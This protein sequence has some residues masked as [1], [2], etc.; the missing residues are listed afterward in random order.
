MGTH[1][2]THGRTQRSAPRRAARVNTRVRYVNGRHEVSGGVKGCGRLS[3]VLLSSGP[4][5]AGINKRVPVPEEQPFNGGGDDDD[6]DET[7]WEKD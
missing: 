1:A 4:K 2:R 5:I 7:R 3:R 6:D